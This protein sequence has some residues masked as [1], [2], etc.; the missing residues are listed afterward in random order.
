MKKTFQNWLA[1]ALALTML[2]SLLAACGGNSQNGGA[3]DQQTNGQQTEEQQAG[4]N[5]SQTADQT[6]D[7]QQ[8]PENETPQPALVSQGFMPLDY[9]ENFSIELYENGCRMIRGGANDVQL[10]VVPEGVEVPEEEIGD[11]VSVLQQPIDRVYLASTGMV[12]VIDA[13]G[14]LDHVKLVATD[15]DG[16]YV[17]GV[18]E[19]MN[20]GEI[21]FSGN[22]KEPDYEQMTANDIQ[23]HVDTTMLDGYPEVVEKFEELGIPT[24][25]EDSSQESHPLARVE[26]VKVFGVLFGLEDE[27]QKYFDGQKA[28][29][30]N[31]GGTDTGKTVA[32]GYIASSGSCYA[33]NG[34]DY[35]A[36]MIG[37]A[38]GDY[39]RANENADESGNQ[40]MTFEEWYADFKDAEYLFYVNFALGF[41][42]VQEMIDYNPLFADFRA[43]QDGHV[44]ITS[45]DFTQS[46]AAIAAIVADMNTILTSDDPAVT[47][48]HLIKI[49]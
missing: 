37:M 31:A 36:Q 16:W 26:W 10:L 25:I 30:E 33:R 1:L 35:M 48:D 40:K 49:D 7:T 20:A 34:G 38:G 47:T 46:T 39:V 11:D 4:D 32:M 44:Y 17:D 22:Y 18:V 42:S 12:S 6:D 23:L 5:D 2:L 8:P 29:L 13:I 28:L 41:H 19:K 43:V 3:D 15:V 9:A 24:F 27:A 45:P 14:G 21:A